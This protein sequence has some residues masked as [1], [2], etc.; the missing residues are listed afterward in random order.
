MAGP[1][2]EFTRL[3]H[4]A[5]STPPATAAI[6]GSAE[7]EAGEP[8]VGL[9]YNP[10]SRRNRGADFAEFGRP[11]VLNARPDTREELPGVMARFAKEGIDFLVIN[12]GDGTVRDV[13]T[14]G[15]PFFGDDW[16]AIAVLPKGKT[17]ALNVDLGAPSDWSL[18]DAIEA[19]KSGRRVIRRPLAMCD[20]DAQA[21][22]EAGEP[23]L[24]FIIGAGAI[25]TGVKVGQ[26][27]HRLGAF[28]S[29][30]VGMTGAWG[31]LQSLFGS[32]R[33]IWRRGVAMEF[34][35][36]E[37]RTPLPPGDYG[38]ATR[39]FLLLSTTLDKLPVGIRPFGKADGAIKLAVMK[40]SRRRLVALFP[41]IAM[42]FAPKWLDEFGFHQSATDCFEMKIG[43][44]FILD[45]EV[46]PAGNYRVEQGARM[47]FV[48]P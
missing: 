4:G 8:L 3:P 12:G 1:I 41:A 48:V 44:Q 23:L 25:A 35:L 24:G 6:R 47:E 16:P 30:A 42:G 39:P 33:N 31:V 9:V 38:D 14:A 19:Y 29:F 28:N 18:S 45:G 26:D 10:R 32:D 37:D 43:D 46:F 36:G 2:H 20:I 27:A 34:H 11:G 21:R 5:A 7:R 40:N 15:Q 17:N 22:G 13:L